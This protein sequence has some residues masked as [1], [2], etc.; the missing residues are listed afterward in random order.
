MSGNGERTNRMVRFLEEVRY[1]GR[2]RR[3]LLRFVVLT[4]DGIWR[5][6]DAAEPKRNDRLNRDGCG[7]P[8]P[9]APQQSSRAA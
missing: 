3:T 8:Q 6:W 4:P 2:G 7:E 1:M 9:Q 5:V